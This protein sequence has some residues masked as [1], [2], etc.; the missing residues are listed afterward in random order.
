MVL[1]CRVPEFAL[2]R[3]SLVDPQ[4]HSSSCGSSDKRHHDKSMLCDVWIYVCMLR[5]YVGYL[6]VTAEIVKKKTV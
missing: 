2:S 5:V 4:M 6:F 3:D 1:S